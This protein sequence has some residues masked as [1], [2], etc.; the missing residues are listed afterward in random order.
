MDAEDELLLVGG[1]LLL[2]LLLVAEEDEDEVDVGEEPGAAVF[3][4]A[5]LGG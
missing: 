2:L 5:A 4:V 1:G 3:T